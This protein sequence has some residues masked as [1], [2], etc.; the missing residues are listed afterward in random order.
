MP[1]RKIRIYLWFLHLNSFLWIEMYNKEQ[2]LKYI[3]SNG[4]ALFHFRI[5]DMNIKTFNLIKD[6][7]NLTWISALLQGVTLDLLNNLSFNFGKLLN[8]VNITYVVN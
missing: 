4:F 2:F 3:G 1:Q 8:M 5:D 7:W 6:L